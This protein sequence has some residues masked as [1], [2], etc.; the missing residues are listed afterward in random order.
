MEMDIH[1]KIRGRDTAKGVDIVNETP[2]KHSL[3]R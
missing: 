1:L 3:L 2:G